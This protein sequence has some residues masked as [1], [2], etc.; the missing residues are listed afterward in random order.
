MYILF[1]KLQNNTS[2]IP[3]TSNTQ[4][5]IHIHIHIPKSDLDIQTP[6]HPLPITHHPSS[7][8]HNPQTPTNKTNQSPFIILTPSILP[9]ATQARIA[10]HLL[11][12]HPF[13]PPSSSAHYSSPSP[14]H[15][16]DYSAFPASLHSLSTIHTPL[17]Y[18]YVNTRIPFAP[19]LVLYSYLYHAHTYTYTLHFTLYTSHSTLH[20]PSAYDCLEKITYIY[21]HTL[22]H[23]TP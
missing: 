12:P 19:K 9:N 13:T 23:S 10:H 6:H 4:S 18:S 22:S 11:F 14:M 1:K 8:T 15:F 17:L 2:Q 5:T 21:I 3:N 16:P 7:I 20:L